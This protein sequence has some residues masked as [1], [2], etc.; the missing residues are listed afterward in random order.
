M[1]PRQWR[2]FI[3]FVISFLLIAWALLSCET[4]KKFSSKR[5]DTTTVH[6]T[7]SVDSSRLSGTAI[8]TMDIQSKEWYDNFKTTVNFKKDTINNITNV[9]PSSI[10]YESA[11]GNKETEAK[12]FDSSWFLN[13]IQQLRNERD[14]ASHI[15][16]SVNSSKKIESKG[17]PA[18][19]F[20][21]GGLIVYVVVREV[22]PKYFKI[23]KL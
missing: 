14:S 19:V 21:V 22:L 4:L 10:V 17:W 20:I 9:Y 5:D 7:A 16:E 8:R 15:N 3:I 1:T 18:W 11:K 23:T 2:H 13:K 6:S 12:S